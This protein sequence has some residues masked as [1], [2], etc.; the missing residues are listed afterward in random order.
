[1]LP[2]NYVES[3][4]FNTNT[5]RLKIYLSPQ[6]FFFYQ[7]TFP[8]FQKVHTL[9]KYNKRSANAEA[10]MVTAFLM[11]CFYTPQWPVY[12]SQLFL[13][14]FLP[15]YFKSHSSNFTNSS[16]LAMSANTISHK[17]TTNQHALT[18]SPASDSWAISGYIPEGMTRKVVLLGSSSEMETQ[19]R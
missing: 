19:I 14:Y 15:L 11:P 12:L 1:M 13:F 9:T 10:G 16:F 5:L 17:I 7:F 3:H 6:N 4:Q 8:F 2:T 18:T